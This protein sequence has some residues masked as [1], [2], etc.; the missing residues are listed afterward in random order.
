MRKAMRDMDGVIERCL[1]TLQLGDGQLAPRLQMCDLA[2]IVQ[3]A[4]SSCP[5]PAQAKLPL[6]C[7]LSSAL[8]PGRSVPSC[9][10]T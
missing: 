5:Q 1:Q 4:V 6:R 9:R 3:D 8:V 2:G 10:R 7:S